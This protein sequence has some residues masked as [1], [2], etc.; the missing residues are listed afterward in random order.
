[1]SGRLK[2]FNT[3][4]YENKEKHDH[5]EIFLTNGLMPLAPMTRFI[6]FTVQKTRSPEAPMSKA[7]VPISLTRAPSIC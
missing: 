4:K 6:A 1:M 5:I 2:I 3:K 7:F